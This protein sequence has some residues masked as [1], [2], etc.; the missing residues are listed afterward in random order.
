M[1]TLKCRALIAAVDGGSMSAAA[2]EL[3]YT[4][5]GII[6]LINA[7]EADVGFPLLVRSHSGVEPTADGTRM[8][9]VIREAV[10]L[11][12]RAQQ[13]GAE[14]RGLV[15]GDLVIGAKYSSAAFWLPQIVKAFQTDYPAVRIHTLEGG[16][17]DLAAWLEQRR[18]DCCFASV[19]PE[20]CDWIPLGRNEMVVWVPKNHP[21]AE[22]TSLRLDELASEPFIKILPG[23]DMDAERLLAEAG[24]EPEV[25][26]STAD[27][28]TTFS[29]VSAGLGI[30]VCS[31]MMARN[32][33]GD[34]AVIPFDPPYFSDLGIAVPSLTRLS[35]AARRFIDCSKEVVAAMEVK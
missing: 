14:I 31:E 21:L 18:V 8:L 15:E 10:S 11:D 33:V 23:H 29:M 9:P 32:W 17:S 3:G 2:K 19:R 4:P 1:D 27:C 22:R 25:R 7:L 24:V 34:V 35:P 30:S 28:Y 26:F 16:N 6:R 12:A 20:G 13:L 5:S